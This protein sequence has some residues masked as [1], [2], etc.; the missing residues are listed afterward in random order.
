MTV[1]PHL[2]LVR[3]PTNLSHSYRLT[4]DFFNVVLIPEIITEII[5]VIMD[6]MIAGTSL[7]MF[8]DLSY[9]IRVH[10]LTSDI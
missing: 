10:V 1:L 7:V 8:S 3:Y 6:A 4:H 5:T 2:T 9:K